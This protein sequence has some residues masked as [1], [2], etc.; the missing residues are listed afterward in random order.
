MDYT[1]AELLDLIERH[2]K[3]E[4]YY[5][6]KL[7]ELRAHDLLECAIKDALEAEEN[8][9][10]DAIAAL[11]RLGVT[12]GQIV[13]EVHQ[14]LTDGAITTTTRIGVKPAAVGTDAARDALAQI[15]N[16]P[17]SRKYSLAEV[18]AIVYPRRNAGNQAMN[19]QRKPRTGVPSH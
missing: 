15:H 4:N 11:L 9:I 12:P 17:A 3:N 7:A 10:D 5:R 1:E 6:G 16:Q 8:A 14:G 13:I 19:N 2:D 18:K